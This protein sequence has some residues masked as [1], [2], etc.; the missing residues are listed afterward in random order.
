MDHGYSLVNSVV[1]RLLQDHSAL[2]W[3]NI[4]SPPTVT[5]PISMA[6]RRGLPPDRATTS[7]AASASAYEYSPVV[8]GAFTVQGQSLRSL[9][10]LTASSTAARHR[11]STT[12]TTTTSTTTTTTTHANSA[13][14]TNPST[15]THHRLTPS[16]YWRARRSNRALDLSA[17]GGEESILHDFT[18]DPPPAPAD[19]DEL[20]LATL[21][22][23][24]FSSPSSYPSF[25]SSSTATT[26]P[27]TNSRPAVQLPPQ[28][29][30]LPGPRPYSSTTTAPRNN[31]SAACILNFS[32]PE[33]T[34]TQLSASTTTGESQNTLFTDDYNDDYN[35]LF[36]S[37][38]SSLD[39][40]IMPP[41]RART[42]I[43]AP[44][45]DR[46]HDS[47]RRRTSATAPRPPRKPTPRRRP[48]PAEKDLDDGIF[49]DQ[50]L[51]SSPNVDL[52][53]EDL[54]TIDLT[55]ATELPE[56]LTKPDVPEVDNRIKI[57]AFQCVIC[58][59]DVTTLTVTHCGHLYCAQCLHSSLN[60]PATKGKCPMCR[61]KLD[62]KSRATYNTKTKGYW[63][64]E[65]KLMTATRKGKRKANVLT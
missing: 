11:Q 21:A 48:N 35:D 3:N 56:E 54:T 63:P 36:D 62:L 50:V 5:L 42:N 18:P 19:S 49:D 38:G 39:D 40:I 65:L 45:Y 10:P 37:P 33:R 27:T 15:P 1:S 24:V 61:Q 23:S 60:V 26:N 55:E 53:K 59:D 13:N 31:P 20:Y 47:K 17:W 64:L 32:A 58:M 41:S 12:T 43:A 2:F 44:P 34:T 46:G 8:E 9:P 28:P 4:V 25:T 57:A 6:T 30:L 14:S 16:P 7:A 52:R 22:D 29:S 51:H